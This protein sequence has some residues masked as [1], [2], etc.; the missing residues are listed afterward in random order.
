MSGNIL[1]KNSNVLQ[2]QQKKQVREERC[3]LLGFAQIYLQL[4]LIGYCFG[5]II[6]QMII[7][8]VKIITKKTSRDYNNKTSFK[9]IQIKRFL[10]P[11]LR[12]ASSF[13]ALAY[14]RE[15]PEPQT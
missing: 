10:L 3:G 1:Q 14:I 13:K 2:H 7:N 8:K 9:K 11:D 12:G 4:I 15:T 6:W 5:R